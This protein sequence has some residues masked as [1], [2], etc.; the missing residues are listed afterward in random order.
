MKVL[1]VPAPPP[2][3]TRPSV[4]EE[5]GPDGELD[6]LAPV[7]F[8][9]RYRYFVVGA[10]LVAAALGFLAALMQPLR[11]SSAAVL[12]L[13]AQSTANPLAPEPLT[14][15]SL[16]RLAMSDVVKGHVEADLRKRNLLP[17]GH[18]ILDFHPQLYKS[19]EPGKPF[20]PMLGLTID[21]TTPEIARD[22]ANSWAQTLKD[23]A[24][25]LI[26]ANRTSAVEFI[27][28]EYP[29]ESQ[30]LLQEE[31]SL[32]ALKREQERA[33]GSVKTQAA[34]SLRE[35]ELWAREQLIVDLEA[36][37]NRLL[38]DLKAAEASVAAVE[39]ELKQVPQMIVVNRSAPTGD[40]KLQAQQVNPVHTEL[41]QQLA[42]ARVKRSELASRVPALQGQIASI[43]KEIPGLRSALE[44]SERAVSEL[45]RQQKTEFDAKERDVL[46]VRS[47]FKKLEERIGDATLVANDS[48]TSVSLGSPAE[49]PAR[50]SGPDKARYAGIGGL[51]GFG[52][53]LLA[54]WIAH[55]IRREP[56][57]A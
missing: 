47:S 15:E 5:W 50:P 27:V 26:A 14:V 29:K 8:A 53:A 37:H 52:F 32:E 6:L 30:R 23:E 51:S 7:V 12:F 57:L 19:A 45:E 4:D 21:A 31:R 42:D 18:S 25:K 54:S 48:N 49:A 38:V 28:K 41:T 56:S 40:A 44:A 39:Q 9:W 13:N 43:R 2:K 34:V 11:Y 46:A 20:L 22:A 16:E 24:T 35:A 33:L 55:R 10:A 36:Q 17:A 3:R 1:E